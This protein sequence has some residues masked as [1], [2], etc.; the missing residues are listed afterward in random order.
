MELCAGTGVA[1]LLA[2]RHGAT[3]AWATD[4]GARSTHFARFNARLSDLPGVRCEVS[5]V[6]SAAAGETFDLVV[7]HPPYVPSFANE[8]EFR[9]AGADGEEITARIVA[10][11]PVHLR[12]GGRCA[13]TCVITDR[14]GEPVE[15]RLRRWLGD[16]A[17][18]FDVVVMVHREFDR[19]AA[20]RSATRGGA[21]WKDA[22]RWLR[23]FDALGILRFNLCAM[24]LR[25]TARGRAPI[26]ARR[27]AGPALD[28]PA[29][30]WTARWAL[31]EATHPDPATR[32][33]D[34]RPR[35][36]PRTEL[37]LKLR[38]G[39]TGLRTIAAAVMTTYPARGMASVPALAPTL[40]ELCDGTRDAPALLVALRAAG[41]VDDEV[42]VSH[43]VQVLELL[44]GAGALETD[45]LPV[46][47][48]DSTPTARRAAAATQA[49]RAAARGEGQAASTA[50][51][52]SPAQSTRQ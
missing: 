11:L 23:H 46:P 44:L 49:V 51:S 4:I 41:L 52:S 17:A 29:M 47:R 28:A 31:H 38:A 30:D 22:E 24:E 40:L 20:Y 42:E 6:W 45:D 3:E 12:Q 16:A 35:V 39:D 15:A 10:G 36:V 18:E 2:A 7:A 25:R 34:R 50:T 5:D 9:D 13:M 27:D 8:L 1:A 19:F 14:E 32:V 33:G 43:V 21:G 48:P 26:T 37:D